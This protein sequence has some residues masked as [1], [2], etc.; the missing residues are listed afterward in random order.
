[1]LQRPR[2]LLRRAYEGAYGRLLEREIGDVPSH[3]AVIQDGNR[4]YARRDGDEATAGYHAGARTT[5]QV[6]EWCEELG[7]EELTLY[8][9]STENFSR[10]EDEQQVLFD[11]IE[12]KLREFAE[13]DRVHE[14]G[15]CI[16]AIGDVTRLPPRVRDAVAHAERRTADYDGFRLNVAL[17]YGGRDELLRAARDVARAVADGE[18]AAADVDVAAV[19]SRLDRTP[20]RDVDLIVRTGGDERTSNFLPW[21]AN[22]NEAAVF[23]CAPFWPEFSR[24]D[25][26]RGIRT[27]ESRE[28]SW[29]RTRTERAVALVRAVAEAGEAE[30]RAVASRLREQLTTAGAEEVRAEVA[31]HREVDSAD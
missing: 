3:V 26:L 1:M 23:F 17:A 22:G 8:A 11:L 28:E 4:R 14:A 12:A 13:A 24:V 25:F 20:V 27:Y 29:Q 10:P 16:R 18:M 19:E 15:V 9:F 2:R 5:E 7:V 21:Q 30:G 6:L 31:R